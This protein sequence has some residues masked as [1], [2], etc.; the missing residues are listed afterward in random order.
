M[1]KPQPALAPDCSGGAAL[2]TTAPI[3]PGAFAAAGALGLPAAAFS[4]APPFAACAAD[5]A[6][7]SV[8]ELIAV[9]LAAARSALQQGSCSNCKLSGH[10]YLNQQ[11]RLDAISHLDICLFPHS[12]EMVSSHSE[13]L[14]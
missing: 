12:G 9:G 1:Q 6:A 7:L 11:I 14:A 5:I 10:I 13:G 3:C 2:A 8:S 4:P